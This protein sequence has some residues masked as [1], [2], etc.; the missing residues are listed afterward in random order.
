LLAISVSTWTGTAAEAPGLFAAVAYFLWVAGFGRVC[1]GTQNV[2]H[3]FR[4]L[5]PERAF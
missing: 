3:R 4:G 2:T 1:W 5:S